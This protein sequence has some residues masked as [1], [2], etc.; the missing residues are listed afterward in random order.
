LAL[1]IQGVAPSQIQ[2][3]I[4]GVLER[5]RRGNA[6]RTRAPHGRGLGLDIVQRVVRLHAWELSLA[7]VAP[8]GLSVV[9]AGPLGRTGRIDQLSAS[10]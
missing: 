9:I 1:A 4:D 6:A 2:A 5:G 3:R 7:N 10:P 8:R